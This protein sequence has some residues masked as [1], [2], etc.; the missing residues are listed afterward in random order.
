MLNAHI[1]LCKRVI[2]QHA[3]SVDV[4]SDSLQ[5]TE[6]A[7]PDSEGTQRAV[8]ASRLHNH[9]NQAIFMGDPV[10][11]VF[12]AVN[13]ADMQAVVKALGISTD[14]QVGRHC[15]KKGGFAL[16]LQHS[17]RMVWHEDE[18]T[19]KSLDCSFCRQMCI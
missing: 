18:F 12:T 17:N 1:S 7:W 4:V 3:F 6:M 14:D 19:I 15:L 11:G 10:G 5:V 16:L 2:E 9:F 8:A 13:A